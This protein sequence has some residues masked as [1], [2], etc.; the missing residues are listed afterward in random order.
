MWIKQ[1][2]KRGKGKK[3]GREN[4]KKFLVI[5]VIEINLIIKKFFFFFKCSK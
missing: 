5:K 2:E 1:W 4:E 3:G